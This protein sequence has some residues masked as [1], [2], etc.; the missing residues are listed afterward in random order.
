[1]SALATLPERWVFEALVRGTVD[2]FAF[3]S[4]VD[5][6]DDSVE[7]PVRSNGGV[8]SSFSNNLW[9]LSYRS[10]ATTAASLLFYC[11]IKR[12]ADFRN[13][14]DLMSCRIKS[15]VVS[16]PGKPML[17]IIEYLM[18]S[19]GE[20]GFHG[21][22]FHNGQY[23]CIN[24][25]FNNH[26]SFPKTVCGPHFCSSRQRIVLSKIVL[27]FQGILD[28]TTSFVVNRTMLAWGNDRYDLNIAIS[29]SVLS[30]SSST[31][32]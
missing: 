24:I 9:T 20:E 11:F 27:F 3:F 26:S 1:M 16:W 5:E 30:Q 2:L 7:R 32:T 23:G 14:D 6:L 22:L 18:V 31:T 10:L 8:T 19:F 12:A 17:F 28:H 21:S 29:T 13:M 25:T 4:F 15:G